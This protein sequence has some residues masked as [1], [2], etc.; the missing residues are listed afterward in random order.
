MDLYVPGQKGDHLVQ[1]TLFKHAF[2]IGGD[3][4]MLSEA[5]FG[6]AFKRWT[7][8]SLLILAVYWSYQS[9]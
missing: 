3:A 2:F 8:Q 4:N 5:V 7:N 1:L 9:C 6:N